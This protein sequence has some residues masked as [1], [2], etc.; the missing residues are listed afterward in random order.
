MAYQRLTAPV[1]QTYNKKAAALIEKQRR[2][3]LAGAEKSVTWRQRAAIRQRQ[4]RFSEGVGAKRR[5]GGMASS[6][7]WQ[8]ASAWRRKYQ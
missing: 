3:A 4:R 8:A 2:L 5:H 1:M 6:A 7:A